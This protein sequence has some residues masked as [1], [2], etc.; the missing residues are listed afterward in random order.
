MRNKNYLP[1]DDLYLGLAAF[2]FEDDTE[3]IS[4]NE[5]IAVIKQIGDNMVVYDESLKIF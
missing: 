4:K 5:G 2:H 1:N 3:N